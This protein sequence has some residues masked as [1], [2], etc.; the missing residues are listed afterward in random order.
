MVEIFVGYVGV[1]WLLD[2]TKNTRSDYYDNKERYA[3]LN[4]SIKDEPDITTEPNFATTFLQL[5]A[6]NA[7]AAAKPNPIS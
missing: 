2:I 5:T 1:L 6:T 3:L 4:R 7:R